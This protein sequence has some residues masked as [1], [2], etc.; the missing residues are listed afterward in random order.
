MPN[1]FITLDVPN[2]ANGAG[3]PTLVGGTGHPKSFV[4]TGALTGRYIVEGSNDGG[5]TWDILKDDNDGTEAL[6]TSQNAGTKSVDC[7]VERVRVRVARALPTSTPPSVTMGAPP[8]LGFNFFGRLDVPD[9]AGTGAVLDLGLNVGPLKT[10]VLRG[11]VPERA[12]FTI[13]A[14]MDGA[15]FD[16]AMLFTS[17]QQGARSVHV[18]CRYLRVQRTGGSGPAPAISVG[19]EPVF[20]PA[21]SE[22]GGIAPSGPYV[23]FG[24]ESVKST[25]GIYDEEVIEE[26]LA[27]PTSVTGAA[28]KVVAWFSG[29]GRKGSPE[30]GAVTFRLR[31]GGTPGVADGE[32]LATAQVSTLERSPCVAR[33]EPFVRSAPTLIKVTGRG[34]GEAAAVLGGLVVSIEPAPGPSGT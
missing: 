33:S 9:A 23:S 30:G 27:P 28:E 19:C 14:S 5:T 18:M 10:F 25:T 2:V 13:Q 1:T 22:S 29:L 11:M 16:E 34:N 24:D 6:F 7:I 21:G 32:V 31:M 17:D 4:L 26:F 12:R 15:R 20:E 8:A 3:V